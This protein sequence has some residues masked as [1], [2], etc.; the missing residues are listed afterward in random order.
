MSET[1]S[2]LESGVWDLLDALQSVSSEL[3]RHTS[4]AE[5]SDAA[6]WL[7]LRLTKSSIAFIGLVDDKG[8]PQKVISRAADPSADLPPDEI[9]R[10]F[11]A[12]AAAQAPMSSSTYSA[13]VIPAF[14]S[15]CGLQ[16][17]AA[18]QVIG[19]MGVASA[20]GYTAVQQRT[21]ALVAD[22]VAASLALA[23]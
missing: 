2:H 17:K 16:L 6:L 19:V 1:A 11:A 8:Q 20:A 9:E 12:A 18:G 21:F 14:R 10:L 3:S 23:Q 22:Q 13:P 15:Y 4:V 5:V 7:A